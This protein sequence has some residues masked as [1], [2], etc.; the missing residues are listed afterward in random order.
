[1][2]HDWKKNQKVENVQQKKPNIWETWEN[3]DFKSDGADLNEVWW[4]KTGLK[5]ELVN[6][7]KQKPQQLISQDKPKK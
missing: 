3:S 4:L 5:H 1:M 7:Y 2:E 6:E